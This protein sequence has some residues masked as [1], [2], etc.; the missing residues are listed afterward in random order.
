MPVIVVGTERNFA[1][2]KPRLVTGRVSTA[3]VSEITAAI[4]AANP[5][6]DLSRLEPG[7]I[8]TIPEDVPHLEVRGEVS[9]DDTTRSAIEGVTNAGAAALE[10]LV[11]AAAAREKEGTAERKALTKSLA[12]KEVTAAARRDKALGADV[13]AAEQAIAD[14]DAQAKERAAALKQAQAGWKAELA[15]LKELAP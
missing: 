8:L 9:L 13:K 4:S 12:G 3:A 15:A 1:A 10:E 2:L 6:A 7:T 5:H 14:E 11:A